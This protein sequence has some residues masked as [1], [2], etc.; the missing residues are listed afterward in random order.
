MPLRL[1]FMVM[2]P[3]KYRAYHKTDEYETK[4]QNYYASKVEI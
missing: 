3:K 1:A 4:Y 2:L